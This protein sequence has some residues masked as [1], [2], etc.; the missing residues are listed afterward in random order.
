MENV[1]ARIIG[2]F[3]GQTALANALGMRHPSTV[4]GWKVRGVVPARR[5]ADVLRA[6]REAG[7]PLTADDFIAASD[8]ERAA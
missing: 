8:G 2:L 3:G 6:A 7:L 1:A 5:Q 4:H